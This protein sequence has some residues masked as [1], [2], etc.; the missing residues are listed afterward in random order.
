MVINTSLGK[1][2]NVST[3]KGII[4]TWLYI[5][6][7]YYEIIKHDNQKFIQYKKKTMFKRKL[8]ML[9]DAILGRDKIAWYQRNN[10]H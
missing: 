6:K 3:M 1:D 9:Q 4:F 2:R 7:L 8:L 10:N 5:Y